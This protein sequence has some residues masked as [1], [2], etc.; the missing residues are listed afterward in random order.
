VRKERPLWRE[1]ATNLAGTRLELQWEGALGTPQPQV[2]PQG[3]EQEKWHKSV[4][5]NDQM[6]LNV[7]RLY[8]LSFMRQNLKLVLGFPSF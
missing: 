8:Q 5:Q 6:L 3:T 7:F 2:L 1:G 4:L